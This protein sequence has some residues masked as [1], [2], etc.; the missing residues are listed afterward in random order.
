MSLPR[1]WLKCQLNVNF[2]LFIEILIAAIRVKK[3]QALM[4]GPRLW[5]TLPQE[6]DH[7]TQALEVPHQCYTFIYSTLFIS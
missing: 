3:N 1:S 7:H 2:G 4:R 6:R 5:I